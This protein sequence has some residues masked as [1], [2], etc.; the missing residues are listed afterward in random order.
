LASIP[1][2]ALGMYQVA[3]QPTDSGH[4]WHHNVQ[5]LLDLEYL[6][7]LMHEP[8]L[9]HRFAQPAPSGDL[10]QMA[11]ELESKVHSDK[12][13]YAAAMRLLVLGAERRGDEM[14]RALVHCHAGCTPEAVTAAR[15]VETVK[16]S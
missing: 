1:D 9:P 12:P 6:I 10:K 13:F 16:E 15:G 8:Q 2:P 11:G 4:D 14:L 7:K 5:V 3:F